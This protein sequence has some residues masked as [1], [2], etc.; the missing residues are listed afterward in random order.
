MAGALIFGSTTLALAKEWWHDTFI[1]DG[2]GTCED[3]D[4]LRTYSASEIYGWETSCKITKTQRINGIENAVILD[5]VCGGTDMTPETYK[6]RELLVKD[7][8][9]IRVYPE[10]IKFQTCSSVKVKNA[11]QQET[12]QAICPI[13]LSILRSDPRDDGTYQLLEFKNGFL[14]AQATL[15]GYKNDEPIWTTKSHATCSNGAV[16]CRMTFKTRAG[17]DYQE[18]YQPLTVA[19]QP[20]VVF[21]ELRQTLF[22]KERNPAYERKAY[23]G[24]EVNFL[25]GYEPAIDEMILPENVYKFSRCSAAEGATDNQ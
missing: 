21:A 23:G 18:A 25:N 8:D 20:W 14:D 7:Q 6:S 12:A 24:I 19:D 2:S 10:G 9:G 1:Q 22:L 15:T 3:N 5:L 11:I 13:S 4:S 16:I 17:E